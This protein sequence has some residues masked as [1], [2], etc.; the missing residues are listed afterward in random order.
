MRQAVRRVAVIAVA[1]CCVAWGVADS[2]AGHAGD[3][4]PDIAGMMKPELFPGAVEVSEAVAKGKPGEMIA[5]RGH[6][7]AKDGFDASRAIF[8]LEET[9]TAD[10]VT[11]ASDRPVATVR[12]V[13]AA[14]EPLKGSVE[15]QQRLKAGAEVFVLG[16]VRSGDG[17]AAVE[18]DAV[19]LHV[20]RG[21]LP[22][23]FFL[24]EADPAAK[25]VSEARTQP[26]KV[27]QDVT[28]RGRIGG[29]T[30]PFVAGRAIFTIVGRAL[31]PCNEKPDD[32]CGTPWDYCCDSKA[33]I[34]ANSVTV[35]IADPKGQPLR[36]SM[37][38][39]RGLRELSE[40]V[41]VGKVTAVGGEGV[42]VTATSIAVAR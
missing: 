37:K 40:V 27:G 18:V 23:G 41:V 33:E 28:L 21:G 10:G 25:D 1:M 8:R 34:V 3:R 5:L 2:L 32:H 31:T 19:A 7:P 14:G 4:P 29:G 11:P 17:K 22:P 12:L 42:V 6:V 26:L 38:G 16:T 13:S 9:P 24:K 15:Q 20:P 35:Q 30:S 39:R 36:T